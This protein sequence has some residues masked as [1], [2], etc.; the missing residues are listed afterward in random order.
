[1]KYF[2]I[3]DKIEKSHPKDFLYINIS[4]S[5]LMLPA[6]AFLEVR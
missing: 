5:N 1:M 3:I 4:L 2:F 6:L